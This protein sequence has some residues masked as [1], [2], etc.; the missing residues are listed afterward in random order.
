MNKRYMRR[1]MAVLVAVAA[2]CGVQDAA[3]KMNYTL[4]DTVRTGFNALDHVLQKPLGNP[5]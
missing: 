5:V 4:N 2:I 1:G 3:A